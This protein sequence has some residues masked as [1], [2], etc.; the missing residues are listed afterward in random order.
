MASTNFNKAQVGL[1]SAFGTPVAPTIQVPWKYTYE[2]KRQ[3]HKAEYDAGTWT[4]TTIVTDVAFET[5]VTLEGDAFFELIPVL[6]NSGLA[7]VAPTGTYIHNYWVNP[8]A[9]ATPKP[10]T[11]LLGAVGTSLGV[12]GPAVKLRDLYLKTL[13]LSANINDK[14]VKVKAEFFGTTYDDNSAAGYAFASVGLPATMEGINGL[15]GLL[16]YGD[17]STTGLAEGAEYDGLT[18]FSCSLLDWEWMLETGI[19]PAW[20]LTDNTTTWST[21]KYTR[22]VCTFK[23]IMRTSSTT[24]AIIKA[25]ADAR[26]YQNVQLQLAG[27][28]SRELSINMTGLWDVVPTVHDEQDGEVV[29]KPTFNCETPHTQTTTPHWLTIINTSTHNWT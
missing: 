10:L 3:R 4:P 25:K 24:Y 1:Q 6:L 2:D 9:V 26:T 16:N 5:A 20:C 23:P 29:I 7:D 17:A 21:L 12:T 28:S 22:P 15:K 13:T 8:A 27:T 11:A 18:S 19:E 14:M